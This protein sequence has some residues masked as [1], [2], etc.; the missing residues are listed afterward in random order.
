M[1]DF[2]QP[3]AQSNPF[4]GTGFSMGQAQDKDVSAFDFGGDKTRMDGESER[5]TTEMPEFDF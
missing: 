4:E 5:K 2:M 1:P 3:A